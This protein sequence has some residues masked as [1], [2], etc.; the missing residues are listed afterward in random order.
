M[1][2]AFDL[3][4]YPL[5]ISQPYRLL[6]PVLLDSPQNP[7]KY[8]EISLWTAAKYGCNMTGWWLSHPSGLVVIIPIIVV[9]YGYIWL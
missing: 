3:N 7:Q 6:N 9:I 5:V 1:L 2:G 4:V 8:G